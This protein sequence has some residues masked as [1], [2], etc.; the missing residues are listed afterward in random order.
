MIEKIDLG[1]LNEN[2]YLHFICNIIFPYSDQSIL[3][4]FFQRDILYLVL[5][6]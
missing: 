6:V 3:A 2:T 1:I 5:H 4:L